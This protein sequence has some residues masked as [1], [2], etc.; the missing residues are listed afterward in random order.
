MGTGMATAGTGAPANT[1][2]VAGDL[3]LVYGSDAEDVLP[4]HSALD[5]TVS[6]VR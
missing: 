5:T 3:V 4:G 2:A 1:R 6:P